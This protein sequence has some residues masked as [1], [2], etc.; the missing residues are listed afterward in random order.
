MSPDYFSNL[1]ENLQRLDHLQR[2]EL[3]RGTIDF[4]V[5]AEYWASHTPERLSM[6]Y[7][8]A[9]PPP[10]GARQP[11]P[12]NFVFAFDVSNEA[13]RSG[14]LHTACAA[15]HDTLFG[16]NACFPLQSEI[17]ILTFDVALHFYDL[18]VRPTAPLLPL[19]NG[20]RQSDLVPMLVLSDIDEVFVP[21]RTGLFVKPEERRTAIEGLLNA[22]PQRF[23]EMNYLD[24]ALGSVI[25]AS[26]AALVST[27]L[28]PLTVPS[29]TVISRLDGVDTSS[30]FRVR[31]PASGLVHFTVNPS[32]RIYTTPR[33]RHRCMLPATIRGGTWARSAL[34]RASE[35]VCFS[36]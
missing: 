12:M 13:L 18:S 29:L 23:A 3:N 20:T 8:S 33:R 9:E 30:S 24:A 7:F 1:D 4:A 27:S 10:T 15:L 16:E 5:P 19:T 31:C 25:R 36:Q 6:P 2:P 17:A 14:T 32:R 11:L 34:R 28:Y 35:S 22:L 26:L 21:L